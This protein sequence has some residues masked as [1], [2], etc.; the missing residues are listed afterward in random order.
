MHIFPLLNLLNPGNKSLKML[1][2]VLNIQQSSCRVHI[3]VTDNHHNVRICRERVNECTEAR[4]SHLHALKLGLSLT[5]AQFELLYNVAYLLKPMSVKMR[6]TK[7]MDRIVIRLVTVLSVRY[8][9][10][11]G[12]LKQDNF[13]SVANPAEILQVRFQQANVGN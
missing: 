1:S 11:S 12:T 8:H 7:L 2:C 13:V 3:R 4:V 5:T 10:K 6:Q 9:Q